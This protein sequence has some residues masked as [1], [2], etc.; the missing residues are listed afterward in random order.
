MPL[1]F[2]IAHIVKHGYARK[3]PFLVAVVR[4]CAVASSGD[5]HVTLADPTGTLSATV[6]ARAL[7]AHPDLETGAAIILKKVRPAALLMAAFVCDRVLCLCV[8]AC[9][10]V[11]GLCM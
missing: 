6:H 8:C 3:V 9:A 1:Q 5:A 2:N 4:A 7:A 11:S 10:C